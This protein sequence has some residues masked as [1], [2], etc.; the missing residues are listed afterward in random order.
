[1]PQR[2]IMGERQAWGLV[3][4]SGHI[5]SNTLTDTAFKIKCRLHLVSWLH[6][7]KPC[8]THLNVTQTG[9]LHEGAQWKGQQLHAVL[10]VVDHLTYMPEDV[11]NKN[12]QKYLW[13][14]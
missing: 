2:Q 1:M 14:H 11:Q 3:V 4:D 10:D 7:C 9:R 5:D 12:K 6:F 8:A 13:Q